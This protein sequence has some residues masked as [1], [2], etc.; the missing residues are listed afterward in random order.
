MI[1]SHERT[2]RDC[3]GL[4]LSRHCNSTVTP[5]LYTLIPK[6]VFGENSGAWERL[7]RPS[8]KI[9]RQRKPGEPDAFVIEIW[10]PFTGSYQLAD[11]VESAIERVEGLAGLIDQMQ[12]RRHPKWNL[13]ADTPDVTGVDE[14][15]WAE[16]R[17]NAAT[18]RSYDTRRFGRP[19]WRRETG[20]TSSEHNLRRSRLRHAH[21]RQLA[22]CRGIDR[23]A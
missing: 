10:N 12:L 16:F 11:T 8:L 14:R 21:S 6:N 13:L 9:T 2:R 18:L 20:L 22:N 5:H 17:I 7:C 4:F 23:R 19:S 15:E 1:E 3:K